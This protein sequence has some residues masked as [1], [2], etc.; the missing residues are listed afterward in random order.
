VLGHGVCPGI[1]HGGNAQQGPAI[2]RYQKE[3]IAIVLPSA[4]REDI[5]R[6]AECEARALILVCHPN[7][8]LG[9]GSL[10]RRGNNGRRHRRGSGRRGRPVLLTVQV[11]RGQTCNLA[12]SRFFGNRYFR[13]GGCRRLRFSRPS[14]LAEGIVVSPRL[15]VGGGLGVDP[16][17]LGRRGRFQSSPSEE[18][19]QPR[20]PPISRSGAA[21]PRIDTR[22]RD[23][24]RRVPRDRQELGTRD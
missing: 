6:I 21:P 3:V 23:R 22:A 14:R 17:V 9:P 11:W 20:L 19:W 12:G 16:L 10:W 4:R 15:R 13:L 2:L 8:R 18:R 1:A 7:C 5:R 24:R